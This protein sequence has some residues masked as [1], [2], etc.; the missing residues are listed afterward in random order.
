MSL[1][2]GATVCAHAN[3]V[4]RAIMV[5]GTNGQVGRELLR[6]LGGLGRVVGVDRAV[7]DLEDPARIRATV[8]VLRPSLI[9][10]SAAYTA[11]DLAETDAAR[12]FRVNARAPGVLA[13]EAARLGVPLIHYSTDY[14]FDGEQESAYDERDLPD[15]QN[16]YGR[17]K[18]AGEEAI[19][20]AHCR[21]L[22]FRS[23]WIY[24][25]RGRNFMR[26]MLRL[27]AASDVVQVVNDQFGAP[28][29]ARVIADISANIVTQSLTVRQADQDNGR[30]ATA[31]AQRQDDW[32][33]AVSGVYHMSAGGET[34]WADFARAIFAYAGMA[35]RVEPI[36]TS[37]YP[38]PARRPAH[39]RLSNDKLVR[40]FGL[41]APHWR[42]SLGHCIASDI[43]ADRLP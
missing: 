27:G 21:H 42:T 15:P 43:T 1:R 9:V 34:N 25:A 23:S 20:A 30:C 32:W 22:I 16:V 18:L 39:S 13:Q 7:L 8:R 29:W 14:V 36:P 26:T 37:A 35:C 5:T 4:E 10:N 31:A 19:R 12:A 40:T 6:S 28:T 24:G 38:A 41:A 3:P 2:S 33:E 11:V 17:S